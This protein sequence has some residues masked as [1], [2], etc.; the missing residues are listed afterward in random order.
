[1]KNYKLIKR[2]MKIE[3]S[4]LISSESIFH[5]LDVSIT[6]ANNSPPD[7][8]HLISAQAKD[9]S[10]GESADPGLSRGWGS[11]RQRFGSLYCGWIDDQNGT[12]TRRDNIINS[13]VRQSQSGIEMGILVY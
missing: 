12:G 3:S 9:D 4:E 13:R 2:N 5:S 6:N 10:T 8:S 1:M 11:E 7:L